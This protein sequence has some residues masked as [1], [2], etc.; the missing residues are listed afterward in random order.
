MIKLKI[1]LISFIALCFTLPLSA[2]EVEEVIDLDDIKQDVID[3]I[4]EQQEELEDQIDVDE[5]ILEVKER[6]KFL[7]TDRISDVLEKINEKRNE[8]REEH[9][10][11][12]YLKPLSDRLAMVSEKI[13]NALNNF[14]TYGVDENTK[15]LGEGERAAVIHSYNQ[16]FDKLPENEEELADAIKIANGRWPSITNERAENRAKEEFR[17]IYKREANME[18][19]NDNAAVTV[20]AYGLRQRAENRNLESEKNGIRI[21]E[22]I[23][24]H[25]PQ[26]TKDWNIMQAITYSGASR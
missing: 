21:F 14:I 26:S 24:N 17:N 1:A 16:A 5:Q 9:A 19:A 6:A 20:M 10:R 23:Y 11:E 12:K 3:I 4:S 2:S 13:N 8:K 25:L 22:S 7:V 18:N 15:R